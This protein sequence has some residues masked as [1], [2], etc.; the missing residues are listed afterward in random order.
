MERTED[1]NWHMFNDFMVRPVSKEDALDFTPKW[2]MPSVLCYQVKSASN[3]VDNSWRDHLD[4]SLLYHD[5]T[6]GYIFEKHKISISLGLADFGGSGNVRYI[7]KQNTSHS[8]RKRGQDQG[9]W[10][11]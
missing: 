8:H 5:L 3:V 7:G 1:N 2:K 6:Y 4:T 11:R 9:C 10:L